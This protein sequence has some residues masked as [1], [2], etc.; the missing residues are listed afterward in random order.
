MLTLDRWS[1]DIE[2]P[3]VPQTDKEELRDWLKEFSERPAQ[4][5]N[6]ADSI[7]PDRADARRV[8]S[9]ILSSEALTD[10]KKLKMHGTLVA[11]ARAYNIAVAPQMGRRQ[12]P[13]LLLPYIPQIVTPEPTI[14]EPGLEEERRQWVETWNTLNALTHDQFHRMEQD[15]QLGVILLSAIVNGALLSKFS[16]KALMRQLDTGNAVAIQCDTVVC[17]LELQLPHGGRR[18]QRWHPDSHTVAL[19]AN[20]L[21]R[22]PDGP[23]GPQ[24][25]EIEPDPWPVL[26]AAH[27]A[28]GL[29]RPA[30]L[31]TLLNRMANAWMTQMPTPLIRYMRGEIASQSFPFSKLSDP[32]S[33][34]PMIKQQDW[35]AITADNWR[36]PVNPNWVDLGT[37]DLKRQLRYAMDQLKPDT[38]QRQIHWFSLEWLKTTCERIESGDAE[39]QASAAGLRPRTIKGTLARIGNLSRIWSTFDAQPFSRSDAQHNTDIIAQCIERLPTFNSQI[40]F[41]A[42]MYAL[43]EHMEQQHDYPE[44][45]DP[46]VLDIRNAESRVDA[47]LIT[48][49]DFARITELFVT[50][51][52]IRTAALNDHTDM[53][54]L[55]R[56]IVTLGFRA[57]LRSHEAWGLQLCDLVGTHRAVELIIRDNAIRTLKTLNAHRRL[58]L[59]VLLSP[60]ELD[61]LLQWRDRVQKFAHSNQTPLFALDKHRNQRRPPDKARVFAHVSAALETGTQDPSVRFHTLRHSAAS[62]W[63]MALYSHHYGAPQAELNLCP[64]SLQWVSDN[65]T[66]LHRAFL[67]IDEITPSIF[68]AVARNCGHASP[69][70]TLHSY[71]HT[72][73]IVVAQVRNHCAPQAAASIARTSGATLQQLQRFSSMPVATLQRYLL[74]PVVRLKKLPKYENRRAAH[75]ENDE[76]PFEL[77]RETLLSIPLDDATRNRFQQNV[78]QLMLI[79]SKKAGSFSTQRSAALSGPTA[80]PKEPHRKQALDEARQLFDMAH[81]FVQQTGNEA[82]ARRAV[83]AYATA[84][85]DS[86]ATV[87]F[88]QTQAACDYLAFLRGIGTPLKALR[89]QILHGRNKARPWC[90]AALAHWSENLDI[91]S[92]YLRLSGIRAR[93]AQG[94][95]GH[96][97]VDI[98]RDGKA[99][100][101]ATHFAMRLLFI[102]H[103]VAD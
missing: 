13:A 53:P 100:A 90:S 43:Y 44:L 85:F 37:H 81:R 20:T 31:T 3:E 56:L 28:L 2:A 63:L 40:D 97:A 16:L 34:A 15:A 99:I 48:H 58:P 78:W 27:R 102:Q 6:G 67:G 5:F 71:I 9:A 98:V 91:D 42:D 21:S 89:L 4:W 77:F 11:L 47:N 60:D 39:Q 17:E 93:H 30:R 23:G 101:E 94:E 103:H 38:L 65:A 22:N 46:T 96:L 14:N 18:I 68:Y 25:A 74:N 57:G 62:W 52:P 50:A 87:T 73:D 95:Q 33:Q 1:W 75:Y 26:K 51:S 49:A 55:A 54:M 32:A 24:R 35:Q 7:K 36:S 59:H 92:R 12:Q 41:A 8:S 61:E 82:L 19:I 76:S 88:A 45:A 66:A 79:Q 70:T 84:R 86:H 83:Q 10:E 72:L 80:L 29:R 69:E 64:D